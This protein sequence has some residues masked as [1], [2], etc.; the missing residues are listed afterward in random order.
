MPNVLSVAPNVPPV[1]HNR[2]CVDIADMVDI[3]N[4]VNIGKNGNIV[5]IAG[6]GDIVNIVAIED[7]VD[8][9]DII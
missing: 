2:I 9:V 1:A 7:I 8:I 3:E 4:I 5:D 6:T